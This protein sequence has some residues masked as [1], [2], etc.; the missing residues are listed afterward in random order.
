LLSYEFPIPERLW[1]EIITG[2]AKSFGLEVH[3]F[4]G[5]REVH[6]ALEAPAVDKAEGVPQFV[7]RFLFAA[8]EEQFFI[9]RQAIESLMQPVNRNQGGLAAQLRLTKDER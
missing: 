3:L 7:Q 5:V 6:N 9:V 1:Q 4:D 8:F 2:W